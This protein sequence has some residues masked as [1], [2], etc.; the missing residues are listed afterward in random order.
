[1]EDS[2]KLPQI[3][4]LEEHG[5]HGKEWLLLSSSVNITLLVDEKEWLEIRSQSVS[6]IHHIG[7]THEGKEVYFDSSTQER[8]IFLSET[9]GKIST[10]ELIQSLGNMPHPLEGRETQK[11]T[12]KIQQNT[13]NTLD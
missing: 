8:G 10:Q 3:D 7:T 11:V 1:M 6:K 4:G 13:Q 9:P 5:G 2:R 12:T